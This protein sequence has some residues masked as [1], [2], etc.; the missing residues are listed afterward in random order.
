MTSHARQAAA[1]HDAIKLDCAAIVAIRHL[2]LLL[3]E[4]AP[5][6][7]RHD[8]FYADLVAKLTGIKWALQLGR[9]ED[10]T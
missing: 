5:M 8:G 10:V 4:I 9:G 6:A 3:A 1:D 7:K 2:D